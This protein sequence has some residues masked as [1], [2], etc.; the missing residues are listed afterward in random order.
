MPPL[1]SPPGGSDG[2]ANYSGRTLRLLPL[3]LS[4][5]AA[6]L[7]AQTDD[8]ID[9]HQN[10][11]DDCIPHPDSSFLLRVDARR[12]CAADYVIL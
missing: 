7:P 3:Y 12:F 9:D 10:I 1:Q 5:A 2:Y 11:N 8:T 4:N 6:G